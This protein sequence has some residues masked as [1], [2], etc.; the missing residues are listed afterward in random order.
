MSQTQTLQSIPEAASAPI[1]PQTASAPAR[2]AAEE[3]IYYGLPQ[4]TWIKIGILTLLFGAVFWSNL[5]RLWEKTN[6]F[7]G[8]PNWGH[9]M[10]VPV[11]GLYFLYVNREALLSAPR[12]PGW[13]GL[14]ILIGG[15][16]LFGYGIWPG[17][18]DFVKDFGMVVTLFGLVALLTGWK[19]MKTA[20]FPIVFLVCGIP[21]PGLVY[22][23]VASPLQQ[24][25]AMVAVTVLKMTGVNSYVGGTKIFIYNANVVRTLNVAEACA[26]LRSLMTFISVAAAVA[27]LSIRPLW[28]KLIIVLSAIPIAV[29]CNVMRV[30]GQGLID[31]YWSEQLSNGFAHAFVG[32]VMLVPAFLMIL[33]VG[34]ILD[35]VFVEVADSK[36]RPA[37][38]VIRRQSP[39]WLVRTHQSRVAAERLRA[40]RAATT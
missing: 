34:W 39:T 24:L 8:E 16:L 5:R 38:Q 30:S 29:F 26:G 18:N 25:A 20:W 36:P 28:Q 32:M 3:V 19:V 23:R 21:W 13:L 14:P 33:G 11:I 17:Q 27:F 4:S 31:H 2:P 1:P 37:A 35:Q 40:E 6:P 15:L 9:A 7:N 10:C 12:R 22:S